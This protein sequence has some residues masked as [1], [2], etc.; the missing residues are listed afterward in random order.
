MGFENT[1]CCYPV[2]MVCCGGLSTLGSRTEKQAPKVI[3]ETQGD[4]VDHLQLEKA[5]F[6][7]NM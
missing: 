6:I 4:A 1:N 7:K 2:T 5:Y 3:I